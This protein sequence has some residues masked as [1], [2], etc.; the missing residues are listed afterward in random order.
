M[1]PGWNVPPVFRDRFT[2]VSHCLKTL[3]MVDFAP[4]IILTEEQFR[5]EVSRRVGR[6]V[7]RTTLYRYRD[8]LGLV[9]RELTLSFAQAIAYYA[10]LRSRRV[11]PARARQLTIKFAKEQNLA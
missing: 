6:D 9:K 4:I 3:A 5:S 1:E 10:T 7:S 11:S 2:F 8:E